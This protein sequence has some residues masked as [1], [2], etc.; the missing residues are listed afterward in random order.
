MTL[1][2]DLFILKNISFSVSKTTV[3]ENVCETQKSLIY[4]YI[5][6]RKS[7]FLESN[8]SLE[9]TC[10]WVSKTAVV[11]SQNRF[12][13]SLHGSLKPRTNQCQSSLFATQQQ[14]VLELK[15]NSAWNCV[16]DSQK[17]D[18]RRCLQG[19]KLSWIILNTKQL[20]K[21]Y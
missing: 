17:L 6:V 9:Q 3:F 8:N 20:L 12:K 18:L 7:S 2:Q 11:E 5:Y 10:F 14:L 21:S 13:E 15:N 4:L 16:W 1:F 19:F